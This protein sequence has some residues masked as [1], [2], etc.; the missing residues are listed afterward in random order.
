MSK[1]ALL[2]VCLLGTTLAAQ[3]AFTQ[4]SP[5]TMP[6]P[7][8]GSIGVSDGVL[9]YHFGGKPGPGVELND[10][11][12]FDGSVWVDITPTTG[13]LPPG[14]DWYGASYD[15]ARGRFVLFG[16]RSSALG[17][18]LGDTWEFD[19]VSWTQMSPVNSPSV[20]R[21]GAMAYDP[22]AGVSILFGGEDL[23]V[24]NNET[25]S[26][27]GVNWTQ[28]SPATSPPI[29]ARGRL[30][31]DMGTGDMIYF[32]G[33]NASIAL[34]DT[35]RWDGA[36]WS[37]VTTANAPSS[38]GVAGRFA[39]G[40]TYDALRERHVLFGGTRNGPTLNDTW[41]FDGIDWEQRTASGPVT[42]TGATFAYVIGQQKTYLFG[43]F[44]GPQLDDTWEYQTSSLPSAVPYGAGCAGPAGLLTLSSSSAPWAGEVW[45]A[46][47]GPLGPTSF[48]MQIWGVSQVTLP[49]NVLVPFS[50]AG[51][52]LLANADLLIGPSVPVAG[53]AT[54]QFAIPNSAPLAG[55]SLNLQV[56]ELEFDLV[57]NWVGLYASN[58]VSMT[59]GVR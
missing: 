30:T 31:Y 57:G 51:C 20:R 41:E 14:R 7:R 37:Q 45:Q 47:C 15:T 1:Y 42:R 38:S 11:W 32:G 33:R 24:Y 29:R 27:D 53:Q 44:G 40:M 43:G 50:P 19:G 26:W 36:T 18:N 46:T 22:V 5:A 56:A 35:W 25:W 16:G 8:A 12:I 17:S 6:S 34:A 58:G 2:S 28:L 59:V 9:L 13:A 52:D 54:A 49:L 39:Y 48:A 21:W 23:G 4:L 10:M 55:A 3:A